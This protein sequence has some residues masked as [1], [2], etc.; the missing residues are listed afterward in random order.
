[1]LNYQRVTAHVQTQPNRAANLQM[2]H[3]RRFDGKRFVGMDLLI[4]FVGSSLGRPQSSKLVAPVP[5]G[6]IQHGKLLSWEMQ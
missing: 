3:L 4:L 6:I 1:M 5:S 2:C